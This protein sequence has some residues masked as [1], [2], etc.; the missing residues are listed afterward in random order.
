MKRVENGFN[1]IELMLLR[2]YDTGRRIKYKN[3][4]SR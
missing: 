4:T 1:A 3:F 2:I